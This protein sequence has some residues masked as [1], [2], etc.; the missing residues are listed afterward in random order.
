MKKLARCFL[1]AV[2]VMTLVLSAGLMC[3]ASSTDSSSSLPQSEASEN[4]A[5]AERTFT[6]N[7]KPD[8][9]QVGSEDQLN[10]TGLTMWIILSAAV[11]MILVYMVFNI[12]R[13][14]KQLKAEAAKPKLI[15]SSGYTR[16]ISR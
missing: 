13:T 2:V 5:V 9:D 11:L 10:L 8:A 16:H 14:R 3:F 12:I 4:A 6:N 1:S 15:I 7:T